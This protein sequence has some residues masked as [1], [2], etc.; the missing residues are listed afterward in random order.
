MAPTTFSKS[1]AC[2]YTPPPAAGLARRSQPPL[3]QVIATIEVS[4]S[5][6]ARGVETVMPMLP[7]FAR[8][9]A[10]CNLGGGTRKGV[11]S[12][13]TTFAAKR[14]PPDQSRTIIYRA[15][16]KAKV[17]LISFLPV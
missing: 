16:V 15:T 10:G 12:E 13:P 17:P 11:F 3:R 14:G 7:Q 5:Q 4:A 1:R 8:R 6:R 2:W 9:P